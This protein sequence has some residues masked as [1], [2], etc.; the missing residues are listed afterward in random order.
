MTRSFKELKEE[1][2]QS[3]DRDTQSLYEE[4]SSYFAFQAAQQTELG[5]EIASLREQAHMTQ[6]ALEEATG[7]QQSEISRIERGVA[8]PTR[9]TLVK[10]GAAFGQRLAFV[11]LEMTNTGSAAIS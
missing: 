9:D 5:R 1:A 2:A 10:L 6:K 7:I 4:A 8:N 3:W 11:P